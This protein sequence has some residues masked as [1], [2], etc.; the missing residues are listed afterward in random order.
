MPKFPSAFVCAAL[1][2]ASS[3]VFADQGIRDTVSAGVSR[4]ISR[5]QPLLDNAPK[6]ASAGTLQAGARSAIEP[7]KAVD[8]TDNQLLLISGLTIM[9]VI[10]KRRSGRA[11]G[12][13]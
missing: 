5:V 13:S 1:V 10:V 6:A 3:P 11:D 4:L 2:C 7:R 9:A 12:N 8:Q